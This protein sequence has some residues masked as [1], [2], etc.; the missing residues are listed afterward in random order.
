MQSPILMRIFL[1]VKAKDHNYFVMMIAKILC[2]CIGLLVVCHHIVNA[3]KR[4]I[5][6]ASFQKQVEAKTTREIT[7]LFIQCTLSFNISKTN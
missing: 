4:G 7:K 2:T 6:K 1:V 5:M 3:F